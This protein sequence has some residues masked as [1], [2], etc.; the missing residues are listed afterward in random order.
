MASRAAPVVVSLLGPSGAGKTTLA[1]TLVRRW[2][3]RGLRV[4]FLKHASHGFEL[5]RAGKDSERLTRAG[6]QGVALSGP[7]GIAY[8]EAREEGDARAL[9]A[10]FFP[11]HDIV[12]LEGFRGAGYPSVV[13]PGDRDLADALA[14]AAGPVLAIAVSG[15]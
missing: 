14:E 2:G 11:A 5:D 1:E 15:R 9:V 8:M 10:R 4:G 7:S 3:G 12:V 13:L 6:A